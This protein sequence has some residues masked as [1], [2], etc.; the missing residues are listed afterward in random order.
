[1][2]ICWRAVTGWSLPVTEDRICVNYVDLIF[3]NGSTIIWS[4]D[5]VYF[6]CF[7]LDFF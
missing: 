4:G 1:M 6:V 2:D 3:E 7:S 5:P